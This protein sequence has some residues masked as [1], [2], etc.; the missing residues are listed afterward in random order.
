MLEKGKLCV[1]VNAMVVYFSKAG[2]MHEQSILK[3]D[4]FYMSP[5]TLYFSKN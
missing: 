5:K 2:T 1:W 3:F 4:T